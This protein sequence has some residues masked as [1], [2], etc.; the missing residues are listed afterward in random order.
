[1]AH[2]ASRKASVETALTAVSKPAPSRSR[3]GNAMTLLSRAPAGHP[4]T[5]GSRAL[6]NIDSKKTG[7]VAREQAVFSA[8]LTAGRENRRQFVRWNHF[9][10]CVGTVA[11]L[12]VR[13]PSSKVRHMPEACALHVLVGYFHHQLRS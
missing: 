6:E 1:V 4:E 13:P 3:L 12:L 2:Y 5:I 11:R 8:K 10:L 7:R 9:E